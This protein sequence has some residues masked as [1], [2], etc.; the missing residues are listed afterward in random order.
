MS[1]ADDPCGRLRSELIRLLEGEE[2]EHWRISRTR[3]LEPG[4]RILREYRGHFG[5]YAIN[6]FLVDLL[7]AGCRM[8]PVE[9]GSGAL[10]CVLHCEERRDLYIKVTIDE[11]MVVILSFHISEHR[12][13]G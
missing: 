3:A 13:G 2:E 7:R 6:L 12:E 11:G 9:L 4:R 5:A 10:A 8:H 1:S